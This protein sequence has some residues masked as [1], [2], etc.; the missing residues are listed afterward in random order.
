MKKTKSVLPIIGLIAV[1]NALGYGIIIP[2]LYSYSQKFGLSDFQ[3]GLLF[4]IFSLCQFVATPIIGRLSDKFGRKPLLILSISGTAISFLLMAF[5][6]TAAWLFIARALDGITAGNIPVASAVISDTMEPKERAKGFGI[7]GASFGF[8]FI[9]GPAISAMTLS[10][11]DTVP[12]LI[13]ATVAIVAVLLTLFVLPETNMHIGIEVAKAKL[14]DFKKLMLALTD[15]HVGLTLIV[16][17]LYSFAFALFIYAYQPFSVKVLH[18]TATQISINFT[19]IGVMG[20][21]SQGLLIPKFVKRVGDKRVLTGALC[22][23]IFTL[24]SFFFVRSESAFMIVSIVNGLANAFIGPMIQTLLSKEADNKS[25]GQ[26]LGLNASYIS[27]GMIFGPII[28]GALATFSIPMPFLVASSMT[29]LCLLLS[30]IILKKPLSPQ[31][32]LHAMG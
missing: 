24:A 21:I 13:S 19:I 7:I 32:R 15:E 6:P 31:A 4:A 26:I 10:F 30:T 12:F 18:L 22:C 20:L 8:G 9:F 2:V 14:F 1:V 17:L 23:M 5:A 25:Q 28:G 3:N 29:M 27:L 11:G 16:S